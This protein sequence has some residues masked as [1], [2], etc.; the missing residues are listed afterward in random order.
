L[1]RSSARG[2]IEGFLFDM[3]TLKQR[4]KRWGVE[5]QFIDRIGDV[6]LLLQDGTH[7]NVVIVQYS[8]DR[9]I[10]GKAV[11]GGEYLPGEN[12]YGNTAWNFG[13]NEEMARAKFKE[14]CSK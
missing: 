9:E 7:W 11:E 4:F 2:G 12:Q 14:L 6:A 3:K 1:Q 5:W 13:R 8:P 10:A